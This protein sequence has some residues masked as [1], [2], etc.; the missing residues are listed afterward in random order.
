MTA[1]PGSPEG[2]ERPQRRALPAFIRWLH[3]YLSLLGFTALLF[4]AITGFTLNH[5]DWFEGS[6]VTR[7]AEGML[8]DPARHS[9]LAAVEWLRAHAGLRGAVTDWTEGGGVVTLLARAPGYAAE[10]TIEQ[11]TGAFRLN[12]SRNNVWAVLDD[13]H[14][15]RDSG[16]GW[17]VL[18]DISAAVMAMTAMT[19]LWLLL[20][21]K[22]RRHTGLWTATVG[23][24]VV[25]VVYVLLV[26]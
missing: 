7:E 10:V 9:Q 20:Y 5:A 25:V 18:I 24:V 2:R 3:T 1:S 22:K 17:S 8:P 16:A 23:T 4:F 19:G 26:P 6:P 13:L 11:A 21:L 14:K 12:E 15:G